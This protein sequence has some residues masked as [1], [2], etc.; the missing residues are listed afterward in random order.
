MTSSQNTKPPNTLELLGDA[1][2]VLHKSHDGTRF[3]DT[4]IRHLMLDVLD[5]NPSAIELDD[6]NTIMSACKDSLKCSIMWWQL[7]GSESLTPTPANPNIF[8][9]LLKS[10]TSSRDTYWDISQ[11]LPMDQVEAFLSDGI[12]AGMQLTTQTFNEWRD[13]PEFNAY[14]QEA[15]FRQIE[16]ADYCLDNG[17]GLASIKTRLFIEND[18][19]FFWSNFRN[20]PSKEVIENQ[21]L[22]PSTLIFDNRRLVPISMDP[23]SWHDLW[24]RI[25][26]LDQPDLVLPYLASHGIDT[27]EADA[28]IFRERIRNILHKSNKEAWTHEKTWPLLREEFESRN[29]WSLLSE[30]GDIFWHTMICIRPGLLGELVKH[31]PPEMLS[32]KSPKGTGIWDQVAKIAIEPKSSSTSINALNKVC[33]VDMHAKTTPIFWQFWSPS[34]DA[35]LRLAKSKFK[36]Q[37]D[38]WFGSHAQQEA[39]MLALLGDLCDKNMLLNSAK[40]EQLLLNSNIQLEGASDALRAGIIL[41]RRMAIEMGQIKE[42][43]IILHEPAQSHDQIPVAFLRKIEPLLERVEKRATKLP[44]NEFIQSRADSLRSHAQNMLLYGLVPEQPKRPRT[45]L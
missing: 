1:L 25:S 6:G 44:F 7:R 16:L 43:E 33:P 3:F 17:D 4:L 30:D 34:N 37:T 8:I 12:S 36:K 35:A 24:T 22:S 23:F 27:T 5:K 42:D 39:G 41:I 14:Q 26:G 45:R 20:R 21:S 9:D 28:N 15:I 13:L 29:K 19:A 38:F 11:V 32:R 2:R 31:V 40:K 10:N 18:G